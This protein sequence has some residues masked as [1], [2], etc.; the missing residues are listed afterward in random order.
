MV[1]QSELNGFPLH[2]YNEFIAPQ[3]HRN[4]DNTSVERREWEEVRFKP[5]IKGDFHGECLTKEALEFWS[6][7]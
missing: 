5:R 6:W 4:N 1:N 7:P 3:D 2:R